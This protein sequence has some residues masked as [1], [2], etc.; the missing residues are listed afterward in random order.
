MIGK[1][2]CKHEFQDKV[3]GKGNRV[4]NEKES[5]GAREYRCT[6]CERITTNVKG[7]ND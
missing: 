1:C 3:Y 6:V 7:G 2:Y 5:K 4:F